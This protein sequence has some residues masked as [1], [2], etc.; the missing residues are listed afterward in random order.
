MPADKQKKPGG[1]LR[2]GP[3]GAGLKIELDF[4]E[5]LRAALGV[6]PPAKPTMKGPG[7]GPRPKPSSPP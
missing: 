7:R 6:K 1:G 2:R 5:A 4:D 3:E